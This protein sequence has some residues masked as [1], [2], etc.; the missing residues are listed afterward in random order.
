MAYGMT[1]GRIES[2]KRLIPVVLLTAFFL[3]FYLGGKAM[4]GSALV[5]MTLYIFPHFVLIAA[6][7]RRLLRIQNG[8]EG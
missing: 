1:L 2:K 8:Y 5:S 6:A 4:E 7:I 3:V